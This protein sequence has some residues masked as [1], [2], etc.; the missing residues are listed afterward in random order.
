GGNYRW[1]RDQFAKGETYAALDVE[2]ARIPAGAEGM[3][4]L[5]SLMG[6]MA[7]TWNEA[8]RG[9]F[10]GFTLAHTRGHFIRALLE[11]SAY[12]VRDITTQMQAAGIELQQLRVVGGG[13]KSPL[14]NQIKADVTG[15]QVNVPEITETTALG[16]AF[17]ALVG[18][19][20]YASLSE[21]SDQIVKIRERIDPDPA[22]HSIY[23]EAY[24]QY[25]QTY[26]ALL[27]VFEEAAR[28]TA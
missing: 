15:L 9:T 2:A 20:D 6:A 3:T 21:A 4:F 14:W 19:G 7:P 17:L 16:A 28:R 26:F 1:L 25:R 10:S 8:A 27:P 23:T 22:V 18:T 13:A 11:G 12:A 24:Q 5:P